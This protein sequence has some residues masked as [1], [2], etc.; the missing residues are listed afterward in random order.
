MPRLRTRV[1]IT[2]EV[3]VA[4]AWEAWTQAAEWDKWFTSKTKLDLSIGGRYS[5]ADKDCGEFL[6]IVPHKLLR[7]SWDN[8]EHGPGSVVTLRF[9]SLGR[10]RCHLELTHSRLEHEKDVVGFR[11]GWN[12]A[13]ASLRNYLATGRGIKYDEWEAAQK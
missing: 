1:A 8:P 3:P 9:K 6:E 13:F 2:L 12:W 10:K 5:N 7:F 11:T 4:R